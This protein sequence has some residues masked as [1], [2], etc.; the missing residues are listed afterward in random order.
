MIGPDGKLL[1]RQA[2]IAAIA[3]YNAESRGSLAFARMP[4]ALITILDGLVPG[5]TGY[6]KGSDGQ[7]QLT[8]GK[9]RKV[10]A[11]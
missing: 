11:S 3:I 2:I 1:D 9:D 10:I 4:R 8:R 5:K 6:V 7:V